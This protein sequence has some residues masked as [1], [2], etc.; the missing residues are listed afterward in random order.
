MGKRIGK[1]K[2]DREPG[3][4]YYIGKDGFVWRAPMKTNKRGRKKKVGTEK[5]KKKKGYMYYL[6]K[7]GY[8]AEAKMARK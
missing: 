5:V 7:K 4:L 6:D 2:I 3:Y 8:V 1:E